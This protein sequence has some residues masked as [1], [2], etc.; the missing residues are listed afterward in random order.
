MI[1]EIK[2][3]REKY[4]DYNDMDDATLAKSLAEKYPDSYSDLPQKVRDEVGGEKISTDPR[5]SSL[6]TE[7]AIMGVVTPIVEGAGM[8]A[9]AI[10]GAPSILGGAVGAGLGY[11]GGKRASEQIGEKAFGIP[12]PKRTLESELIETPKDVLTGATME[13]GG[14][15]VNK[16]VNYVGGKLLAPFRESALQGESVAELARRKGVDLTPAEVT[17]SKPLA[18]IES[19]LSFTPGSS[20]VMQRQKVQELEGLVKLREKL[21]NEITEGRTNVKGLE[22]TGIDIRAKIDEVVSKVKAASEADSLK[23]KDNLL[24]L[25][26]SSETYETVGMSAQKTM[27]TRSRAIAEQGEKLYDGVW[28]KVKGEI[29]L[30]RFQKVAGE[31]LDRET[32]KPASIQKKELIRILEDFSGK[33]KAIDLEGYGPEA[34]AQIEAELGSGGPKS[35][36]AKTIQGIRSDLNERIIAND[37]AFKTQQAGEQKML[38]SSEGGIYKRLK[39]SLELDLKEY[40]RTSGNKEAQ[41]AWDVAQAFWREG[42]Q[43]FNKPAIIRAMSVNPEKVI[44]SVFTPGAVTPIRQLKNAIGDAEFEKVKQG[45]TSKIFDRASKGEFSWDKVSKELDKYGNQTLEQIYSPAE[46]SAIR[47]VI[48]IGA[49]TENPVINPYLQK[50]MRYSSPETVFNVVFHPNNSKNIA[51]IRDIVPKE[52]FQDAKRILTEKILANNEFGIYRPMPS[53]KN[54][55]KFDDDT[56]KTIYTKGE[57]QDLK[58]IVEISKKSYGAEKLGGNPSQTAQ[59][60]ITFES[61]KA[62]L[63]HPISGSKYLIVPNVMARLYLSE[64]GRRYFTQGFKLPG[65]LPSSAGLATKLISLIGVDQLEKVDKGEEE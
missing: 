18:L 28:S 30:S 62:V 21:L 33:N 24:K 20:G 25:M 10:A 54:L 34:R 12:A 14:Q 4:P 55:S 2:A 38:S 42:K 17:G 13:T 11:A 60:I 58:D 37:V 26:G 65:N 27:A 22:Q 19:A 8:V 6:R 47:E 35:Y 1:T 63:R 44:D 57:L 3:F 16:A 56:L 15:V 59:S 23:L 9:G 53:A 5:K 32:A 29:P 50:L 49:N 64:T 36:S 43:T 46:M 40:F 41:E 61:G 45:F 48:E 31:M 39:A 52:T 7:E 51:A